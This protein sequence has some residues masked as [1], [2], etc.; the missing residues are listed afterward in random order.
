MQSHGF[1]RN[2]VFY[3]SL[4]NDQGVHISGNNI[5][6]SEGKYLRNQGP[7]D[8]A[9][10]GHE[11]FVIKLKSNEFVYTRDGEFEFRDG[12]LTDRHSGGQVQGYDSSGNLVS[13]HDKG[14]KK[15][16][17]KASRDVLI[18]GSFCPRLKNSTDPTQG[19]ENVTFQLD[20]IYDAQGQAH[21]IT[22]TFSNKVDEV[23]PQKE[24]YWQLDS[25]TS[26]G[27]IIE[28]GFSQMIEFYDTKSGAREDINN[29]IQ[30][31]LNETQT[32]TVYFGNN[33][34]GA[35][36]SVKLN[37]ELGAETKIQIY[38]NDGYGVG[39]Q[40]NYQFD[41]DGLI[42]YLYDNGQSVKG[43]HVCLARFDDVERNLIP[44]Q[45]N[46]YH[47]KK[48]EGIHYGRANTNGFETI[49]ARNL[50]TSNVDST[51]EFANIVVLQRM[52]QACS[53]IMDIDK[54][55]LEELGSKS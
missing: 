54:Q 31:S 48:N 47:A 22:L 3:S 41:D 38:Q 43:I 55:L 29:R 32:V 19:Y 7:T 6:F 21:S 39:K 24:L 26:D 23:S 16:P 15:I 1:K 40:Y 51:T 36:R 11:F 17:G 12:I 27:V 46:F 53:Q 9:I 18:Q 10:V 13:I 34:D 20:K 49:A 35:D 45:N 28:P 2:D 52:F 25:I 42:T 50:E 33:N 37:T 44:G 5:N 4:G 8:L 30:F 14:P